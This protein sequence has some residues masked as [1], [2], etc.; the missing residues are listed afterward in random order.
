MQECLCNR[1]GQRQGFPSVGLS[2]EGAV[3]KSGGFRMPS[4]QNSD[5]DPVLQDL[6][7]PVH[8]LGST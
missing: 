7:C 4:N 3:G 1:A 5:S 6:P 2:G 8:D